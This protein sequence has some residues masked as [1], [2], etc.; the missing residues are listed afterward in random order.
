M[1]QHIRKGGVNVGMEK[2]R[3]SIGSR[4]RINGHNRVVYGNGRRVGMKE[5]PQKQ[6]Q[7][8]KERG[9]NTGTAGRTVI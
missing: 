1:Q 5:T 9:W 3:V 4:G 7:K 8:E 6:N 2:V